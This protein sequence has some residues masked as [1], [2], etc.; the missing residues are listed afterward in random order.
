[1][2]RTSSPFSPR[3]NSLSDTQVLMAY[4]SIEERAKSRQPV[5]DSIWLSKKMADDGCTLEQTL[6]VMEE[7][8][9]ACNV[10]SPMVCV[11]QCAT[12][13]VKNEIRQVNRFLSEAN[14][15]VKLLNAIKNRRRLAI[16]DILERELS[17]GGLQKNLR[18]YEFNHSK[19][20]IVEYLKPLLEAGLVKES[21][22]RF[23]LTLYGRKVRNAITRHGFCSVHRQLP[24]HSSGHEEKIL[25]SLLNSAKTRSELLDVAPVKSLS[26][27]L[28][29]LR[30][31]KLI[32]VNPSSPRVFYLRTKRA[33]SLEGLSPAQRII[34]DSI[35]PVGISAR[36]LS[37]VVG[38][39]MRR[40]YKHLRSLRGKKL[41]FKRRSPIR[42]ELT[43]TGRAIAELLEGITYIK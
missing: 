12:W 4:A 42:Y 31:R 32:L 20:T 11:D 22:K 19:K 34:C 17:L 10:V 14:H 1:M 7:R 8:C 28:K 36:D 24:I 13:R 6:H 41:V 16:L 21:H 37:R 33:L 3:K 40:T 39:G 2:D 43:L 35:P 23:R 30:E 5:G 18:N 26:R 38:I 27:I 9:K 15:G 25:R 29:R